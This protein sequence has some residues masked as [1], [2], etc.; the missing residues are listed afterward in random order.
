M[1]TTSKALISWIPATKGGRKVPPTGPQYM[2]VARFAEDRTWPDATWTL[3]VRYIKT[4]EQ[5]RF[6]YADVEFLVHEAPAHVLHP[7]SR[8]EL[9]EGPRLVGTGLVVEPATPVPT[10]IEE[11]ESALL[12]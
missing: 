7:G 5:G 12:V 3:V 4:F 10:R 6:L 9:Y 11:F 8:F 1:T 2:T